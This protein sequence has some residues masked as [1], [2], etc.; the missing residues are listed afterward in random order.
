MLNKYLALCT[1]TKTNVNISPQSKGLNTE[2]S[3]YRN[4]LRLIFPELWQM[5]Q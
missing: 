5:I 4:P 2:L 3:K 1:L